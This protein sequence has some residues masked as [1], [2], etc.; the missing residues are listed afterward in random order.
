MPKFHA[1]RL[2]MVLHGADRAPFSDARF[3]SFLFTT[4]GTASSQSDANRMGMRQQALSSTS[5]GPV[6]VSPPATRDSKRHDPD[7]GD[8]SIGTFPSPAAPP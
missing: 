7:I 2:R 3:S 8:D 6:S 4:L 1:D 5:E